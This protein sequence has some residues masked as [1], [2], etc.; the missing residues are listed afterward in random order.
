MDTSS[1]NVLSPQEELVIEKKGTEPPFSG[2]Y[3]D[4]FGLP[5]PAWIAEATG[6]L[7]EKTEPWLETQHSRGSSI[8]LG[9]L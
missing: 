1:Y 9:S 5:K 8:A 3:D 2:E 6:E 4:F 7:Y